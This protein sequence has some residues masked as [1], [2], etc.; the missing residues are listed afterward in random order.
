MGSVHGWMDGHELRVSCNTFQVMRCMHTLYSLLFSRSLNAIEMPEMQ[1]LNTN[2]SRGVTSVEMLQCHN[3]FDS[4]PE[5]VPAYDART[6]NI[7]LVNYR[8]AFPII[9]A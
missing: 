4:S 5:P 8:H 3:P 6:E 2:G 9:I 7:L 1:K